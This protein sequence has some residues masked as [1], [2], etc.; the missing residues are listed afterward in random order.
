MHGANW[1]EGVL[2]YGSISRRAYEAVA[3]LQ[4]IALD[5]DLHLPQP[6]SS[7]WEESGLE[8]LLVDI[9]RLPTSSAG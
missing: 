8:K 4:G 1:I 7:P 9:T 3:E 5:Y 2:E 6:E